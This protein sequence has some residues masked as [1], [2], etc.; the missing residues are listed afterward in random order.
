MIEVILQTAQSVSGLYIVG[1]LGFILAKTGFFGFETRRI[2]PKLV[3]QIALPPYLF[4]AV[5]T[6]FGRDELFHLIYGSIIPILSIL[7]TFFL[8]LLYC[9]F[10]GVSKGRVGIIG[11]GVGASNTIFIG[12][13]VNIALFGERALPFVL[14]YFF[15][16]SSFFWT[17]GNYMLS[18][19]GEKETESF[20]GLLALKAIMSPPLLG[21]ILGIVFVA[22]GWVVPKVLLDSFRL[23][24]SLTTPLALLFIGIT[25]AGCSL[26]ALKPDADLVFV[27][28][29]RFVL[30]P[31]CVYLLF[32]VFSFTNVPPLMIKVFMIQSSLPAAT[33]LALM[34]GYH[35]G[36]GTFASVVV[37]FSTI[38]SLI[39]IPFFM[40]L[41]TYMSF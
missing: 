23:V 3:T 2:F 6:S 21:F 38:L 41:F 36:D 15:A 20:R 35:G 4:T 12:L 11:V 18:R 22:M 13:P 14:L 30:S 10:K 7:M 9:K 25:M 8:G 29:G 1:L 28:L 31:L 37:S 5:S 19:D 33:N 24:G 39:T 34:A 17:I 16:N 26:S 40:F 32:K 27:L